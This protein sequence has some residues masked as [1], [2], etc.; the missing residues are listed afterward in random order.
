MCSIP[1]RLGDE[2]WFRWC[3]EKAGIAEVDGRL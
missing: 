3:V 1:D 2:S